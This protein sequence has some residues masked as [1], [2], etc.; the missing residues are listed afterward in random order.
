MCWFCKFLQYFID[1][2]TVY[3]KLCAITTCN[4]IRYRAVS[5]HNKACFAH[6]VELGRTVGIEFSVLW[7][8]VQWLRRAVS[9]SEA[10]LHTGFARI[11]DLTD[12]EIQVYEAKEC[13]EDL[14]RARELAERHMA[15]LVAKRRVEASI[16]CAL[17]S[18]HSMT[19]VSSDPGVTSEMPNV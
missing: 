5:K 11:A 2:K 10:D 18:S 19:P 3:S 8:S 15:T 9:S 6:N 7:R 4:D 17:T 12:A 13:Y 14:I 16:N 1:E